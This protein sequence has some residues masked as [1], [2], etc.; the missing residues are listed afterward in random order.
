MTHLE[1]SVEKE[2]KEETSL[3]AKLDYLERRMKSQQQNIQELTK[4]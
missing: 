1:E 3:T 2:G 4:S